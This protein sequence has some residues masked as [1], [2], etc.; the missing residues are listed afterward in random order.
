[1][2]LITQTTE[3]QQLCQQ[4]ST[5][6]FITVDLEF[7][8]EHHYYAQL[9][10]IQIGSKD[11][12]AIIDPLAQDINLDSFFEL[13]Q[14]QKVIKVFHSGR[15]DIEIIYHLSGKIPTPLFDTQIAAMAL[16]YG[17]SISYESLVT[18]ILHQ[19]IDKTNR[20]SD[21]SK[22][23]LTASQLDYALSDVT[24]LIEIYQHLS[25]HLKQTN[26]E[27]WIKEEM[28]IL[29]SPHTY[30]INP[31]EA[32]TK[33]KHRSHSAHFLT[34]LR[35]L[36]AWREK[37][38]QTKNTPRQSYIKDDML[39]NICAMNPQS[40][41]ELC[42]IRN[43]RPDI[44]KGKLGDEILNVLKYCRQIP[45]DNYV[46]PPKIKELPNKS[47]ALFELLKLLLKIISQQ[48]KV[49]ARL[50]ATDEDLHSF[51]IFKNDSSNPILS[52]WRNEIFGKHALLLRNGKTSIIYN[53]QTQQIEIKEITV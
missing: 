47:G 39:L 46:T 48:E 13:M 33:I 4:L 8:R 17:E 53:P 26:R 21:W 43:L 51:A 18:H 50:I 27:E 37:R 1:M 12:C 35:E 38:S 20:L 41:E 42:Q 29:T 25:Q 28:E 23:P 22:R 34:L 6:E 2:Q 10:L 3:L 44:A 11:T 49:V 9:C 7:L 31:Q 40:K 36:A 14:D 15:Q 24:H 19:S 5:M 32:W 30:E 16:G 52:G 45:K